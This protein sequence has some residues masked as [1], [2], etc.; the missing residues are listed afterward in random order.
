MLF[1]HWAHL[2]VESVGVVGRTVLVR[3]CGRAP[4]ATCT[5]C[6]GNSSRVHSRYER[7]PA[8]AAVGNQQTVLHLRIRRFF[9]DNGNCERRTFAEQIPELTFRYGHCTILLRRLREAVALV[10]GGR[11]G[12]RLTELQAISLGRD[13]M[14]RL[15]RALPDPV[16][17]AVRALGV[18]DFALKKG[19]HY[20]TILIDLE[21]RRPVDLLPERS[22]DALAD[23]LTRHPGTEIICRDRA[24]C[25][26]EGAAR[27]AG[28]ATQVA[29]RFHLWQNLADATERLVKRLRAEW[30]PPTPEKP[31]P[32]PPEEPEGR[33]AHNIRDMHAAVH[34]LMA[35]GVRHGAIVADLR[36]DPKTIRKYMRAATPEELIGGRPTGRRTILDEHAAYLVSRFSEGCDSSDLLHK[37]LL[38]RGAKVSERTVRR[39]VHRL[40]A[41]IA[42]TAKPPVP[43][44]REVTTMIL[45]HPDRRAEDDITTLKD[46]RE[47][48]PDLDTAHQLIGRF[49][50]ILVNRTGGEKLEPWVADA[51][52]STLPELRKFATGLR[53]DWDAVMAGLSTE[54]SSG[55]VE[56]HVN[57]LKLI[58]RQMFGRGKPDLLRKRVLLQP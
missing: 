37:E 18:D 55:Q 35:N 14:I 34:A 30:T 40:K 3:A 47:R 9:C 11:A 57:R 36:K 20:G 56:G 6:G 50:G 1:P 5:A 19:N 2:R 42:P 24:S 26:A 23:W 49:A 17:G 44:A 46:L 22:A 29:D 43:T 31:A 8:D 45:T 28:T 39:F 48:C 54:W 53:R 13:A 21:T 41:D 33:R 12:A 27:A 52:A 10:L 51:E 16:V 58:K 38:Q 25:Y 32:A 15:I 7:R 4:S